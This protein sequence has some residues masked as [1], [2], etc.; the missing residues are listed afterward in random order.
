MFVRRPDGSLVQMTEQAY[1]FEAV[2]QSLIAQHPDLL[3]GDQIDPERPRRW[4][5]IDQEVGVPAVE[6]GGGYWSLDH[7]LLDQD[8]VPTLVEVKRSTDTRIRREVVGQML[9]Y[10]ANSVAFIPAERIRSL[11]K[12]RC[13]K[14]GLDPD[15]EVAALTGADDVEDFWG[16]VAVNLEAG[17]IRLLLVA[18]SISVELRRIIEFWN[19][20]T[21]PVEVLG[22]EVRQF[23]GEDL[24]TLVPQ[25]FGQTV[26]ATEKK[27]RRGPAREWDEESFFEAL[28]ERGTEAVDM[29]RR[30]I[31]WA[32]SRGL[33]IN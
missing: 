10:A 32:R 16:Q 26:E 21:D 5:L 14:D 11:L 12:A 8:G 29:A 7:L 24:T 31:D 4:L 1:D 18:D 19:R 23:V 28:G 33:R 25:V 2:L 30:I 9:D 15:Q 13:A 20:H 17:R 27:T 3:A 6:G 22:V